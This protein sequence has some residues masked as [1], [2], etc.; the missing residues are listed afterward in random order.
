[1]MD[2][3]DEITPADYGT[4]APE[5]IKGDIALDHVSFAYTDEQYVLKNIHFQK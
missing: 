1:V 2:N 5:N 4:Y 3:K